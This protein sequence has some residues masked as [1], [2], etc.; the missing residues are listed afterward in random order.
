MRR[1]FGILVVAA[2]LWAGWW[3]LGARMLE[4]QLEAW[5]D[6]RR[7]EGW[8]ADAASIDVAGFPATFETRFD[9]V[10]L[11]DPA[12]GLAWAAPGL[13]FAAPAWKPTDVT[14]TLPAE[15]VVAT[16]LEKISI[17]SDRAEA[18]LALVPGPSL[19]FTEATADVRQA[20]LDS[21]L[22]WK[23]AIGSAT[24]SASRREGDLYD[25]VAAITPVEIVTTGRAARLG[26]PQILHELSLDAT[27]GFDRPWDRRAIEDRRPQ[28]RSLDLRRLKLRWGE[29]ELEAAGDLDIDAEGMANG[30]IQVRAV[31]WR[32]LLAI[33]VA[34]GRLPAKVAGT[35]ERGLEFLAAAGGNPDTLELPLGFRDGLLTLGPI[36][37]GQAPDFRIR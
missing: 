35:L 27:V 1:L 33:A 18:R 34:S 13:S 4:H 7:A 20:L 10:D 37:L 15:H 17:G 9:D 23:A 31:N 11:A 19:A 5:L 21:T 16:P 14:V 2:L 36:P 24:L 3:F 30:E 8:V 32:E 29:M 28:P 26:L 25:F 6:A 22:G 12:T